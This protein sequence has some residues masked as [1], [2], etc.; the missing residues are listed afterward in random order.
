RAVVRFVSTALALDEP[1]QAKWVVKRVFFFCSIGAVVTALILALG[2]GGW[3]ARHIY[4][5]AVL[6][7]LMPIAAGWLMITALQQLLV[8]KLHRLGDEGEPL[9]KGELYAL[10]W[11]ALVTNIAIYLLGTSIDLW[12]LGAFRGQPQ[13]ALYGVA[14]RV[15]FLVAT[16]YLILQGVTPP[17]IAE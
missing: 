15:M 3:L 13:V 1:G 17:L 16:P 9:P 5:D 14:S 7:T 2:L 10:A 6:A 4:H 12:I 11:P 8:G